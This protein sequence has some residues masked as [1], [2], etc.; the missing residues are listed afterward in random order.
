MQ[1]G[2]EMITDRAGRDLRAERCERSAGIR[3]EGGGA[4]LETRK[5][6][7]E[8]SVMRDENWER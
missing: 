2:E 3:V 4:I 1:E 7:E 6:T 5:M 8:R